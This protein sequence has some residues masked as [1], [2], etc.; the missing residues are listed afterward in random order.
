MKT[1][2]ML[3]SMV[4]GSASAAYAAT[5][6][7]GEGAGILAYFFVGFFALIIVTQ[8]VPAMILFFGLV[9]GLLSRPEKTPVKVD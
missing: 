6:T 8:L 4:A 7:Q 5:G 9:K 1:M 2:R 3:V